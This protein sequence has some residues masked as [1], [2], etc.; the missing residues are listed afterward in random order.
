MGNDV[1][2]RAS[3]E[4]KVSSGL[5]KIRDKFDVL[6]KR[7]SFTGNVGAKAFEKGMDLV[8]R[9][10]SGVTDL[11]TGAIGAA[12]NMNETM[13]KSSAVF[14]DN[15]IQVSKWG[16]TT[17]EK[18]GISKN[19]AIEAAAGFG[20]LFNKLGL[21]PAKSKEMSTSLVGLSADLA[22]FNN[23]DPTD[24]LQKLKSGLAGESE[25]LRSLGVFLNEGKVAAK[26]MQLGLA[27]AHGE[28]SEGAKVQARYAL[29]LEETKSAQGD[30]AKTSDGLANRQRINDAKWQDSLAKLGGVLLPIATAAAGAFGD[31]LSFVVDHLGEFATAAVAVG[32]ALVVAAIPGVIASG[33]A[34]AAAAGGWGALAVAELA[35]LAPIA[36]VAAAIAGVVV[37]ATHLTE[38]GDAVTGFIGSIPGPWH[39]AE[40]AVAQAADT[41]NRAA[42]TTSDGARDMAEAAPPAARKVSDA[43]A[44]IG[45]S[46]KHAET[47]VG[48]ALSTIVSDLQSARQDVSSAAS[49][50]ADAIYGPIIAKDELATTNHD[51]QEQQRIIAS[52]NSTKAQVSDAQ[53]R[54]HE[55][56]Q[57]KI[58]QMATLAGYGDQSAT[59]ALKH[60]LSV[61]TST[62]D[63]TTEQ[64]LEIAQLR[65]ALAKLQTSYN[66][67]AIAAE[68]LASA[69]LDHTLVKPGT[70]NKA[71]ASGGPVYPGETYTVGEH[72]P[73]TLVMGGVG[74]Y[75]DA[76]ART[77]GGGGEGGVRIVGISMADI[78]EMIDRGLYFRF[79]GAAPTLGR[80]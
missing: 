44:G 32:G 72:G 1:R 10:V 6:D 9:A 67:T 75:V 63:L 23:L 78:L 14:G 22:S 4:D 3:L 65:A 18:L 80:V 51:I 62:K 21:I 5:D 69:H 73:E 20:D 35:A 40:E 41:I 74:G 29:I 39:H 26:A 70:G 47:K 64:K 30:F 17:A 16:D 24:V 12:S 28:L 11:V 57:T 19:S 52:K 25:P 45:T 58:E 55:L 56:N 68:R 59:A 42:T 66:N 54:I 60:Q 77:G 49:D 31:G 50:L 76:H 15:A 2:F 48:L 34:A 61:L 33:V 36:A 37:V 8:G 43:I 53:K 71:R 27:G 38:I 7:G 79:Q 13:S 46:A